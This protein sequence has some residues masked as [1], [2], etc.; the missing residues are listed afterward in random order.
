[1]LKNTL[2]ALLVAAAAG[3]CIWT[4]ALFIRS[5]IA[6]PEVD[7]Q[8]EDRSGTHTLRNVAERAEYYLCVD[9]NAKL[10]IEKDYAETKDLTKAFLTLLTA[11]LVASITFSEKIVDLSRASWWSRGLM[12]SCWVL[13]LIAIATCGAGLAFM[14]TAVGWAAY[15]PQTAYR[16][17]EGKAVSLLIV[18]GLCFGSALVSLL[19]A[20]IISLLDRRPGPLPASP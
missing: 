11:L 3:V 16:E 6:Q 7:E 20:G 18:A 19:I 9:A 12:I 13:L 5:W 1:M 14:T 15:Y 4:G 8:C 17:F 2:V 10:F